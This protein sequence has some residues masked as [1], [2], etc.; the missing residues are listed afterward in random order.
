M[1]NVL[2]LHTG[3]SSKQMENIPID[4][5]KPNPYQPRKNISIKGLEELAQSIK[6]YGVIQPITVR[7]S[8]SG[9][10]ELIAGERRLRAAKMA[11]LD[12]IC[13]III[14]TYEQDSAILAM[15]E[16][17]Q[18][19]NLHFLE[20]A[21]GYASLI[22][23]H[24]FTQEELAVKLGKNQSTIANKLR[25][26]RLSREIKEILIKAKLSERHARALLKLPDEKLQMQAVQEVIRNQLN[27]RDTEAVI[28]N[29]IE[30]IRAGFLNS[31]GTL[32]K[33]DEGDRYF[34][35]GRKKKRQ[36]RIFTRTKDYRIFINTI[37]HAIN[38]PKKYGLE[39][40]Y[41]QIDKDE[42]IEFKIAIQKN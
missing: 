37:N 13:S 41:E 16:N 28:D 36:R 6:Q 25:I 1:R 23:D 31:D 12:Y 42:F 34:E 29:L 35:K 30:R 7:R 26:L 20:E 27:V 38:I 40:H 22:E 19:E 3:A 9:G 15:I 33:T 39:V 2:R 17:L 11:G 5:I 18:R 21:E 32:I 10:Y 24:G 4:M 14:D 8:S